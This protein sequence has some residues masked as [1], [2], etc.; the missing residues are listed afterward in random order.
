MEEKRRR[1]LAIG[2]ALGVAVGAGIGVAMGNV[3]LGIPIGMIFGIAIGSSGA[4]AP[5]DKSESD[6]PES[7]DA[8]TTSEGDDVAATEEDASADDAG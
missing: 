6:K 3:G 7:L 4:F 2:I 8:T 1:S 5:A